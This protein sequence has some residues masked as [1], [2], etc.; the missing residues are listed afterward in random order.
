MH[1]QTHKHTKSYI[2]GPKTIVIYISHAYMYII[3]RYNTD[4]HCYTNSPHTETQRHTQSQNTQRQMW[5]LTHRHRH[6]HSMSLSVR[7]YSPT[8]PPV[9]LVPC[10]KLSVEP[11]GA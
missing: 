11:S 3:D 6:V 1:G 5:T 10:S 8:T 9:A 2:H 4:T 7:V